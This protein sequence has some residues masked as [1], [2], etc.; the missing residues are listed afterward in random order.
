MGQ[1]T[2]TSPPSWFPGAKQTSGG[3]VNP[4][5]G[6][7]LVALNEA[8]FDGL[9]AETQP[10]VITDVVFNDTNY[11]LNDAF[12][13]FVVFDQAVIVTGTPQIAITFGVQG[14]TASYS[15]SL[16][17]SPLMD[18]A[19]IEF[20]PAGTGTN[21]LGFTYTIQAGDDAT[22]GNVT[23]TSPISLNGGTI[24]NSVGAVVASLTLTNGG[25]GYIDGTYAVDITGTPGTA[26]ATAVVAAGI[27]TSLTKLNLGEL[28]TSASTLTTGTFNLVPLGAGQVTSIT[29]V[30]GGTG[31]TDGVYVVNITGTPGTATTLVT[32]ANGIVT[33]AT[34][35]NP[36]SGFTSGSTYTNAAFD[37]TGLGGGAS[38]NLTFTA[39][40]GAILSYAIT[41][42]D[43]TLTF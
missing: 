32:I 28:F 20:L 36:G 1:W 3:W 35:L 25:Q 4:D 8:G 27:I 7:V 29:I 42:Y 26:S 39:G 40:F 31:Y 5:T 24:K 12:N 43:A 16:T 23:L 15:G 14:R 37:E 33:H 30:A 9:D 21:I 17:V 2:L 18:N 10:A 22:T 38:L 41:T 11:V 13:I 6:E 34:I 19:G